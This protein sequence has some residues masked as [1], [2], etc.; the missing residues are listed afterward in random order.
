VGRLERF[1]LLETSSG[2]EMANERLRSALGK[3]A[4]TNEEVARQ[5]Q[6]DPKTVQKWLAGR[7]P[8]PRHRWAVAELV[9]ED[10]EYLWPDA[11]RTAVDGLGGAAEILAAFPFRANVDASRWRRLIEQGE[12]QIDILGYTLY[13]LPQLL[14]EFVDLLQAKADAGCQ[15]RIVIADP[16]S[17][18]V[19]LRDEEEQEPITLVARINTSLNAYEPMLEY[20][21]CDIRFQ[22]APLYNSIY[23]FDDQMFVT[24]HLYATPGHSAPLLHLRRLGPAGLFS[25]F[26]SHF[27]GI[28]SDTTPVRQDRARRPARTGG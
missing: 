9:N 17:E 26:A 23:R 25:R 12:R 11:P 28:W 8:H 3:A 4:M 27:E 24:P 18:Q 16:T 1:V 2:E 10:E 19:R 22:Q 15:I 6:V 13:F 7:V 21:N 14:P 20:P 5:A